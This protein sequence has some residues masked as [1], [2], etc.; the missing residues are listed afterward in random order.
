M[1]H[2]FHRMTL[3][4][5]RYESFKFFYGIILNNETMKICRQKSVD[6]YR[7]IRVDTL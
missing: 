7:S 4:V 1:L 3:F 5:V 2:R 6:Q